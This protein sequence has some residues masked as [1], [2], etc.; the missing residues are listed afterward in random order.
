VVTTSHS[1]RR[2]DWNARLDT[3]IVMTCDKD[4]FHLQSDIDAYADGA[5]I[6][7]RCRQHKIPR[8][9]L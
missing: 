2:G 7:S 9:H 4:H 8:D 1:F 6:F 5:R 3:K